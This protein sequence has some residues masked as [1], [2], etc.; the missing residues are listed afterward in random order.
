[1]DERKS[2]TMVEK[3]A[4]EGGEP[5]RSTFLPYGQQWIDEEDI[6]AVVKVL[7]SPFLTQGPAIVAFEEAVAQYIG[8]KHAIAFCNG[9]AA[10][11]GA[12]FAAGVTTGD[13]VITTPLTFAASANAIGYCDATVVFADV[14]EKLYTIDPKK[15]KEKITPKTKVLLPVSYTGQLAEMDLIQT[16]AKEHQLMVIEDGAH[17][18]GATYKGKKSGQ[19]ADMTMFSFH[20]VKHI[21]TGEGGM[22]VTDSDIFAQKLRQ[23]RTHGIVKNEETMKQGPW[24]YEMEFLGYNY[25][26]T[27]MSATL[28][29]S[30]LKKL[31]TFLQRRREIASLY[32][33]A[34]CNDASLILPYQHPQSHSA[35]HLYLLRFSSTNFIHNRTA[36]FEA[37][38][39]ENIGVQV[40]YIPVHTLAYYQGLGFKKGDYPIVEKLYEEMISLP[41]FPKMTNK[42]VQD[43]ICAVRKIIY[44]WKR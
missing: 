8:V 16:I 33:E 31:D 43:V 6:A 3:L 28:G 2:R 30:Q 42:D 29:L 26:M 10:L 12:L 41:L 13:E 21:T 14:D 35:Y 15:I 4:I 11:H 7:Q 17:S 20:P 1:M 40:H 39:Q 44:N 37:L 5:V 22:I 32:H 24:V 36:I 18:L 27:D 25:R 38:H 34:F 23:F 9:T 19:W